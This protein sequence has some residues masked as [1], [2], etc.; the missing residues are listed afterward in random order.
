MLKYVTKW[1]EAMLH[2]GELIWQ[3]YGIAIKYHSHAKAEGKS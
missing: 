2:K 1:C 3:L